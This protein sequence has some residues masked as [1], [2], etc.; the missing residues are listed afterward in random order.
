MADNVPG[1]LTLGAMPAGCVS[2][3]Q[4]VTCT[5]PAPLA[6]G[7]PVTFEIPVTPTV[8]GQ[9]VV[10]TATVTGGGDSG[11]PQTKTRCESTVTTAIDAPQLRITKE[12]TPA[13]FSV[14]VTGTYLLGVVNEGTE[15]HDRGRQ[16]GRQC[17]GHAS[18]SASCR[19]DAWRSGS[20]VACLI[21]AGLEP[22]EAVSFAIPVTPSM[23]GVVRQHGPG[24]RRR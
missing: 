10:N 21:P 19:P 14:G 22:G 6:P 13:S 23:G 16:R 17:P 18:R 8:A 24:R 7:T 9:S 2:S 15:P 5:I 20:V 4:Q 12:A 1:S 11:C 3:G